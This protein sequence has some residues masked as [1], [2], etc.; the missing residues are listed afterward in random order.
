MQTRTDKIR[1]ATLMDLSNLAG[2]VS[3]R[4]LC[5]SEPAE[6]RGARRSAGSERSPA[7]I[8]PV[9]TVSDTNGGHLKSL[10]S[11]VCR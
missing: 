1:S 5:F 10:W 2:L 3:T 8:S 6:L 7:G 11:M 9:F 4:F